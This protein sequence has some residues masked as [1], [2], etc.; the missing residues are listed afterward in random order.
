MT[1][2]SKCGSDRGDPQGFRESMHPALQMKGCYAAALVCARQGRSGGAYPV[3]AT[4]REL[5]G[6]SCVRRT[7]GPSRSR[8]LLTIATSF[9]VRSD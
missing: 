4:E 3:S 2:K 6:H 9:V 5:C 7:N 1:T 8:G